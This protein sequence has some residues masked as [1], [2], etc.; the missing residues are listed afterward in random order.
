MEAD[1]DIT[2]NAHVVKEYGGIRH[3]G[4]RHDGPDRL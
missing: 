2:R 1:A 3:G 4:I